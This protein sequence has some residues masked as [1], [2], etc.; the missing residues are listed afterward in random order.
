MEAG[1]LVCLI[2]DSSGINSNLVTDHCYAVVGYDPSSSSPFELFNPWGA[3]SAGSGV[4]EFVD[5]DGAALEANFDSWGVPRRRLGAPVHETRYPR[6]IRRAAAKHGRDCDDPHRYRLA[7]G[8][9]AEVRRRDACEQAQFPAQQPH[10]IA[11]ARP[12]QVHS[13]ASLHDHRD[14]ALD[15]LADRD[16]EFLR[17]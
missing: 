7:A 9:T 8:R 2:S 16:V 12:G 6:P 5:A 4:W 15:S 10:W 11:L 13:I 3:G 14:L 17:S 1:D